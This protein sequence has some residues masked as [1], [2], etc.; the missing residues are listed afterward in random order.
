MTKEILV[1]R[2]QKLAGILVEQEGQSEF[3]IP[4]EEKPAEEKAPEI[5][6]DEAQFASDPLDNID[7]R[8]QPL[9]GRDYEA[10]D[11][12][13]MMVGSPQDEEFSLDDFD[14]GEEGLSVREPDWES[15]PEYDED[16]LGELYGL[17]WEEAEEQNKRD[18]SRYG[19]P[20]VR[21]WDL[22]RKS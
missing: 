13:P 9:D 7:T 3:V 15:D 22:G 1:E 4:N 17:S 2:W 8:W 19:S 20:I 21:D 10:E 11:N 14:A 12:E 5:K 6:M 16:E 18:V